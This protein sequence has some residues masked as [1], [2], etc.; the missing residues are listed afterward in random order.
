[1]KNPNRT[2]RSYVVMEQVTMKK[3]FISGL[4]LGSLLWGASTAQSMTLITETIDDFNTFQDFIQ[5]TP[6]DTPPNAVS[7]DSPPA[8][9][10]IGGTRTTT[11]ELLEPIFLPEPPDPS[12]NDSDT[13]TVAI[14][15]PTPGVGTFDQSIFGNL[16]NF[17]RTTVIWNN[18]GTGLNANFSGFDRFLLNI[19]NFDLLNSTITEDIGTITLRVRN[20]LSGSFF[21]SIQ[22]LDETSTLTSLEFFFN[23][24][25]FSSPIQEIELEVTTLQQ[26]GLLFTFEDLLVAREEDDNGQIDVPEPS[27][28]LG[29][30]TLAG[31]QLIVT[32][33]RKSRAKRKKD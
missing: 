20:S 18:E 24:S 17:T 5:L 12:E 14:G 21:E 32:G 4:A 16:G 22:T 7:T 10:I 19:N 15:S 3:A 2:L 9:S 26:P 11:L 28:V 31:T 25:V 1:M 30:L 8:S 6:L 23:P 27:L 29:C 13:T 33:W